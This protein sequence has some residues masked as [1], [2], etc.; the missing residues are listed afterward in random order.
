M[1]NYENYVL[2][3]IL[4]SNNK[5]FFQALKEVQ[6][7]FIKDVV[8]SGG[9]TLVTPVK[10]CRNVGLNVGTCK[11]SNDSTIE[12]QYG[13]D[14]TNA[15][16]GESKTDE[17][18]IN[19]VNKDQCKRDCLNPAE[20]EASRRLP[21]KPAINKPFYSSTQ[22]PS[23]DVSSELELIAGKNKSQTFLSS[24]SQAT[25]RSPNSISEHPKINATAQFSKSPIQSKGLNSPN[26]KIDY[27]VQTPV[28]TRSK[29]AASKILFSVSESEMSSTKPRSEL[30][31]QVS[32]PKLESKSAGFSE[33]V[34]F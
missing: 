11:L 17:L 4:L 21:L 27:K 24:S 6:N 2:Y 30:Q 18:E 28:I 23:T 7:R 5:I 26:E 22:R 8:A 34:I 15:L 13:G 20:V 33:R 29:A 31:S 3:V 1:Y 16:V 9:T 25:R 12:N 32:E 19:E 10:I 14:A